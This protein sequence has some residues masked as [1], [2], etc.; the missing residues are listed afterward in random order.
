MAR[1]PAARTGQ[2]VPDTSAARNAVD[3]AS[4][5]AQDV[6]ST[7]MQQGQQVGRGAVRQARQ[8][9]DTSRQQ[10]AQVAQELSDQA[11]G[12]LDET[13]TQLQDQAQTQA[14]RMAEALRRLGGEA[15]ALAEGRPQDAPTLRDSLATTAVK[16][17]EIADD[18]HSK[19]AEGLLED[20]QTL[21]RSHP[22]SF[23]LGAGVAGLTIGRLLRNAKDE[24]QPSPEELTRP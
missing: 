9:L 12:L 10:G 1:G 14:Q 15:Q 8:V 20:L 21:A 11:R 7:A 19:G 13:K 3:E 6:A 22:G 16:L 5:N 2:Q 24:H 23:L 4:R 18:L 17:D